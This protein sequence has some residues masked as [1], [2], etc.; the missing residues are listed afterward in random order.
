M[1]KYIAHI[2]L[3]AQMFNECLYGFTP[4]CQ[5]TAGKNGDGFRIW[6][7]CGV[8]KTYLEKALTWDPRGTIVSLFRL[9]LSYRK[10]GEMYVFARHN[11]KA[12]RYFEP[13]TRFMFAWDMYN[14]V[15]RT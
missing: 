7:L 11:K 2:N 9:G 4:L 15:V 6:E 5:G 13:T 3:G 10:I 8:K 14:L 12:L 1:L